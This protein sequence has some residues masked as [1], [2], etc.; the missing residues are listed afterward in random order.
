[1]KTRRLTKKEM[2]IF[3]VGQLGWSILGGLINAWLVTFYLPTEQDI[4]KGANFYLPTGLIIFG[5][6][7]IL[8]LI[9][10]ICRIFDAVTDPWIASL[11]DRST[12]PKGRRIPFMKR[13]AIPF[14]LIT[15]LV[16][17]APVNGV[18]GV[19]IAWV[20]CTLIL[21][22]LFMTMYCTPYNALISEFGKTQEDRMY[23]STAISLT[24]FFGTL[25]AYLP[26]VFAGV[27]QGMAVS[28]AWSYRLCFIVLSAIALVCML[29]PVFKLN[30]KEF[31][32]AV[33]SESN[34]I[35][36]LGK[37]FQN[38]DF[39]KFAASDIA[40][41]IGLTLFQTGLPFFVKVSME[42]DASFAM[43]F[44]GGMTVLSACF[45]PIVS[46]LVSKFG[47]KKLVITGFL[48][49][50]LAYVVTALIGVIP[51][52][53]GIVPGALIVII[54]AFPM[55]L[56]GIIPQAIVADVAEEDAIVTGEK[57]EGMFFAARTFA[58]KM[59]QSVAMLVFTSLAVLGTTQD[60]KSND[61][62]ASPIG[63]RIV[64]IVAICFCVLGAVILAAYDEKKV[65]KTITDNAN[66]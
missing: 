6:L 30:E 28:F 48:G 58:M 1:M 13:A 53:K 11:S 38:K 16:F 49:L 47:K 4:A 17:F 46:K 9:A 7:T 54:S 59:G 55:A 19:N 65:M 45:Y 43:Y 51:G 39:V 24:F 60:L 35:K 37:T 52:F 12:N 5:I 56:L 33:P 21:F 34:A 64:A 66:K 36:S 40:Y 25:I 10:F 62:T 23:I 63:L 42:L 26:F 32:D 15:V 44:L 31:V 22:Y 41:W 14:A 57:R 29:V 3:A 27:L 2:R 50:A 8:G 18:S 61:L 20:L